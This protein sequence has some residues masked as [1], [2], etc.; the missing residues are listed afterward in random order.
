MMHIATRN[1]AVALLQT[2]AS[3]VKGK[4]KLIAELIPRGVA[5]HG[6]PLRLVDS[7]VSQ[8]PTAR[9]HRT[10]GGMTARLTR[11]SADRWAISNIRKHEE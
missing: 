10:A 8:S 11:L 1:F 2:L 3:G 9:R 7:V 5:T 4:A 6:G